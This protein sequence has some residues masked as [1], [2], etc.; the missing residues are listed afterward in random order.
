MPVSVVDY[1]F[2]SPPLLFL[3]IDLDLDLDFE[4]AGFFSVDFYRDL[5]CLP[6]FLA[7]EFPNLSSS[8]PGRVL[9][10][11]FVSELIVP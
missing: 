9:N 8:P 4:V 2:F 1:L 3:P 7:T 5:E 10:T 11:F 6:V